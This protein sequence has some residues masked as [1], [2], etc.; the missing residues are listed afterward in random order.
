MHVGV[1]YY[2]EHRARERWEQDASLMEQAGFNVVRMAEFAWAFM[3]PSEGRFDFGWLDECLAILARHGISAIL[4]TPT[5]VMPAWV[6]RTYPESLGAD[7]TGRRI[8]WGV[9]K[10]NCFTSGAY[11]LLSERITRAMAE[12]FA[13]APNVIGWQTDN[14]F[15]GPICFCDTCRASFHDWLA[16][17][18]GTLEEVNRA[19]GTHFWGHRY[20]SWQEIPLPDE[21]SAHN[22]GLCLD[23]RRFHSWLTVRFQADQ[24]GIIRRT[25]PRHFVT[26]NFMGMYAE[27][28]YWEL[29]KD[30]DFV[31]WDNYPVWG[32]ADVHWDAATAAD[33][34][35]GLKGKNFW[36]MEQTAGAG[37]WG[38]MGRN[39]RPGEIRQ[40][41]WQQVAHGA[42]GMVW[43]RWDTCTAGREQYWHGLLGHDDLPGRRYEEAAGVAAELHRLAP[44]LE[45]TT[46][47]APVAMIWDYESTWAFRIQPAYAPA[48]GAQDGALNYQNAIRRFHRALF[49]AGV[50]VDMVRPGQELAGYK[51]VIAPHLYI[52]PDE[53]ASALARFVQAGGVLIADCRTGVKDR[54]GLMHARTLPGLLTE[55]LGIAIGE[56]E[57]LSS[58][59]SYA[60]EAAAPYPSGCASV[61]FADWVTAKTAES[62]AGYAAWH[63]KQFAAL[64]RNR[65]GSGFAYYV[66][67]VV[68]EESFYDALVADALSK[69]GVAPV[70]RPP[71]GVEAMVREGDGRRLL[72]LINHTEERKIVAGLPGG[73]DALGGA[74]TGASATLEPYGVKVIRLGK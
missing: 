4:G 62:L 71:A 22:P 54:T 6:A 39:P 3:E 16:A 63:M 52:L 60:I 59:M 23:H 24:V 73:V 18:Y 15:G 58:D 11:R 25:C 74:K 9:R 64:T 13:A 66:G 42:D 36:I 28:D 57:A 30:V 1:D 51:V 29:A 72:F 50:G 32:L 2:P 61:Q 69:A 12:R 17:R 43:F 68:R 19:W 8:T 10:N 21:P 27:L 34:M 7:R 55:T 53:V 26:H 14:E 20:G 56:Y 41:V 5:A 46:V 44:E 67:T 35:R 65:S 38:V 37:G 45:G 47:R 70:V 48:D 40:I 49:R 33:V 31:S